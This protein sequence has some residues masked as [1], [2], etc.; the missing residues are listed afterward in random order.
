MD[1]FIRLKVKGWTKFQHYKHRSPPWIKLHR[2][3]LDDFRFHG[4]PV[5]SK[6]LAPMLWLLAS[7]HP[8][9]LIEGEAMQLC[10]RLRISS[11]DF[12]LAIRPLIS[13]GF[14]EFA[15][16]MLAPRLHDATPEREGEGEIT[17]P[18]DELY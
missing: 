13:N 3:L 9:G 16:T 17:L 14:F 2:S 6:A 18:E 11:D 5:A 4:L 12:D 8:E 10:F 7:E 1:D 15:S